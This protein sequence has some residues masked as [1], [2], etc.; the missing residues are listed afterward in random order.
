[1]FTKIKR[2]LVVSGVFTGQLFGNRDEW[3]IS[4][5]TMTFLERKEVEG[6]LADMEILELADEER[7]SPTVTSKQPKHW[8]VFHIIA[9]RKI[10]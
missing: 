2:S 4:P 5:P 1:M 7:D 8:H 6:L 9:R 3:N 10:L